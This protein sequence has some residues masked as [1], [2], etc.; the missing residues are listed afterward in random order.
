MGLLSSVSKYYKMS[1][2]KNVLIYVQRPDAGLIATKAG[3]EKQTG[4]YLKAGS[5]GIRVVDM[6]NPKATLA[7]YFDLADTR[8]D[9]EGFLKA[10]SAVWS[11]ERQYRP[12]V[13][14]RFHQRFGTDASNVENCLCQLTGREAESFLGKYLTQVEVKDESS[15][16][17]GL[18]AGAVQAEFAKLVIDSAAYIV[19]QKCG[20]KTEIF[21]EAEA[22]ENISHFGSLEL[23]MGLGA[24]ACAIAR[25]VLSEL[26]KS[27]EEIKEERSQA[28]EERTVNETGIPDGRGWDA[29]SQPPVIQES[30]IR[31]GT[32]GNLWEKLE[33]VHEREAPHKTVGV[34]RSGKNQRNDHQ[35][36]SGG[37]GKERSTDPKISG[38]LAPATD[39]GYPETGRTY[40]DA[41]QTGRGDHSTRG[42]LPD[43]VIEIKGEA[44]AAKK[45]EN[46]EKEE[47]RTE[48]K[49]GDSSFSILVLDDGKEIRE[50]EDWEYIQHLLMDTEVYPLEMYEHL[51]R[52][53]DEQ[54]D[55]AK[56]EEGIR[57][58]YLDYLLPYEQYVLSNTEKFHGATAI[59]YPGLLQEIGEATK[60]S[61]FLLPSSLHEVILMKDNGEM[62]AEELQRMVMQINRTEVKPEEVLSDEV[63]CYDYREQKLTM[64]TDPV[65]TKEVL[66]QIEGNYGQECVQE[67]ERYGFAMER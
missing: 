21:S 60:S 3:W 41:D 11:L 31:P 4:R 8:G 15:V 55:K 33:G 45:K 57:E 29:L 14:K 58:I 2:D 13:L 46:K 66:Q 47:S 7:Y 1:F 50:H 20:I 24:F 34:N 39:G 30:G 19:F 9:Y 53:F 36:G 65:K 64:A 67:E 48:E 62:S 63:Y 6:N 54:R 22:F 27:I 37:R 51:A 5:K 26:H 49:A 28:D 59:L 35:S 40:G 23:F 12:E 52:L 43:K 61:F 18:P 17:Y 56:R 44:G 32:G 10:M 16:L 42:G 25:P 38:N